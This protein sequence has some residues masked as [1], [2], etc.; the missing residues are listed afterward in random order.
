MREIK[1]YLHL[2]LGCEC[3]FNPPHQKIGTGLLEQIDVNGICVIADIG[4]TRTIKIQF[5]RPIL[6]PIA[7]LDDL[8]CIKIAEIIYGRP[9]SVKWRVEKR[10]SSNA[11]LSFFNV[12]RRHYSKSFTIDVPT[13]EIECYEKEIATT[14]I[15]EPL[16]DNEKVTEKDIYNRQHEV[17]RFFLSHGYDIFGLIEDGIAIDKTKL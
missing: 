1:D 2:Y 12:Y 5:L 10:F 3:E 17:T 7:A 8:D 11:K 15:P 4:I 13:G 9:D 14:A 16:N 6:K